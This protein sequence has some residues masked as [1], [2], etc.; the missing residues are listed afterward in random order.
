MKII[1]IRNG[2]TADHSST[3]YEFLAVDRP[4]DAQARAEVAKLSRRAAPTERSV[5]FIYH[6]DG[7]DIP[8]GWESLMVHYYDVMV[9]E[10]YDW[11]TFAIAFNAP[12]EQREALA[13]Y[14]FDGADDL[15]VRVSSFD[16]RVIVEIHC[17]LDSNALYELTIIPGRRRRGGDDPMPAL[18][19]LLT[20]I[21]RQLIAD[22]YRAL[23]AVWEEYGC[24][25]EGAEDEEKVAVTIPP[26][27]PAMESGQEIVERFRGLLVT[28]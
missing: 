17:A 15:G 20:D 22:D 10:S 19:Q 5:S 26:E 13:H 18:L 2:F 16:D 27:P 4:L 3:S 8:G 23:Y 11:W 7:Y 14:A 28:P 6:M 25:E 1:S 21:R 12:Q 9:S 24:E